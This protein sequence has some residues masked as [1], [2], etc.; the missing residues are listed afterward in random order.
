M[1]T[2]GLLARP[3]PPITV[4]CGL[5]TLTGCRRVPASGETAATGKT[6]TVFGSR[7]VLDFVWIDA[8]A[9][10]LIR[11]AFGRYIRGPVNIGSGKEPRL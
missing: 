9:D 10:A 4:A 8:A 2:R 6:I 1:H 11:A 3:S 7:K 5:L